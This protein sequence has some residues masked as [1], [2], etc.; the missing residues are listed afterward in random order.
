MPVVSTIPDV[1][2][3]PPPISQTVELADSYNINLPGEIKLTRSNILL[4][5]FL[6]YQGFTSDLLD[7]YNNWIQHTLPQ[8][9]AARVIDNGNGTI[10]RVTRLII[11]KPTTTNSNNQTINLTPIMCRN[12]GTTYASQ[13]YADIEVVKDDEVIGREQMVC[14]GK[15]PVMLGSI[16]CH[17]H[18]KSNQERIEMGECPNDPLS[19][20]IIKGNE[21]VVLMQEKL[22][23]NRFLIFVD[24]ASGEM[25][26][27]MTCNTLKGSMIVT[28]YKTPI[29]EIKLGLAFLGKDE[30]DNPRTLPALSPYFILSDAY[31]NQGIP[32]T[33]DEIQEQILSFVDP[34]YRTKVAMTLLPS[35]VDVTTKADIV[36]EIISTKVI[37]EA[38]RHRYPGTEIQKN[39]LKITPQEQVNMF[40]ELLIE[41]LFPNM[42][43]APIAHKLRQLS[44]MIAVY[45][46][47]ILGYRKPDD[48]NSWSN[49]RV[50]TAGRSL[51]Q[52]FVGVWAK[53]ISTA[54]ASIVKLRSIDVKSISRSFDPIIMEQNL[55]GSFEPNSW[56]VK[57]SY[58]KE[59]ITDILKR[60]SPLALYSHLTLINTPTSRRV[61]TPSIRMVQ[62][63]Q[64]GFVDPVE[65]SEG[66]NCHRWDTYILMSDGSQRQIGQ[67]KDGDEIMTINPETLQIS[68]SRIHSHFSRTTQSHGKG[69]FRITSISG[70]TIVSTGDHPFLTQEGMITVCNLDI[71]RHLL[72]IRPTPVMLP[73]DGANEPLFIEHE[74]KLTNLGIKDSLVAKYILE[75]DN[76]G[77]LSLSRSSPLTPIL[78]RL[79]G[80][81]ISDGHITIHK[82]VAT[83]STKFGCID[84]AH[85]FIADL[86]TLGLT[87]T[88]PKY[89]IT[90]AI[91]YDGREVSH[92]CWDVECYGNIP[93]LFLLLGAPYGK[94]GSKDYSIPDWIETP[95]AIREFLAAFQGGDGSKFFL[96]SDNNIKFP[97]TVQHKDTEHLASGILFMERLEQLFNSLGIKTLGV[98]ITKVA[99]DTHRLSLGFSSDMDNKVR[100]MDVIGYRYCNTKNN[101]GILVSEF[102]KYRERKIAEKIRLKER[103]RELYPE[104]GSYV[105]VAKEL[106]VSAGFVS[107]C[108]RGLYKKTIQPRDTMRIDDWSK[109]VQVKNGTIFVPIE[110]ITPEE[111]CLV[112]DFT[113]DNDNHTMISAG[114]CTSNCG[115]IKAKAV[116]AKVTID[117][118]DALVLEYIK[119]KISDTPTVQLATILIVNGRMTGWCDGEELRQYLVGLRRGGW[120]YPDTSVA[121]VDRILYIYTDAARLVRPLLIV[122]PNGKLVIEEKNLWNAPWPQ[123]VKEQA[124]EYIDPLEQE[125][126]MLAQSIDSLMERRREIDEARHRLTEATNNLNQLRQQGTRSTLLPRRIARTLEG[127]LVFEDAAD[128][129]E[130]MSLDTDTLNDEQLATLYEMTQRK[131]EDIVRLAQATLDRLVQRRPFTHCELDPNAIFGIAAS[132]IPLP[133]HNQAPRNVYQTAMGKQAL[134]IYHSNYQLRFDTTAKTLAFPTR[135]LFETQMNNLLGLNTQP[136]GQMVTVAIMTLGGYNQEDALI[137]NKASI[138][139]GL[140]K[141]AVHRSY[142]ASLES[143]H[144]KIES[145]TRPPIRPGD[146]DNK[147][148][149]LDD[150][151]IAK[152]GSRIEP[153]M[154]IIGKM[155]K[156]NKT[157]KITYPSVYAGIGESG[158][159]VSVL[160][161]VNAKG[162]TMVRVKL[163]DIRDPTYGDKFASRHA[164]KSTVGLILPEHDMPFTRNG[165]RPDI[166]INPHC[167]TGD[168]PVTLASGISRRIDQMAYDGGD[169]VW[170]WDNGLK[171]DKQLERASKGVRKVIRLTLQDGRTIKCTEEHRFLVLMNDGAKYVE[172]KDLR[173]NEHRLVC[174]LEGAVDVVGDDE[175]GWSLTVG[176]HR[177]SMETWHNRD[178]TLALARMLGY[179]LTNRAITS[180]H[181]L[182]G[183]RMSHPIDVQL[184]LD[185]IQLVTGIRPV[186]TYTGTSYV[187]K[188]PAK[189]VRAIASLEGI[190]PT[191]KLSIPK[192]IIQHN[193]PLAVVREFVAGLFGG[194][195]RAPYLRHTNLQGPVLCRVVGRNSIPSLKANMQQLQCVLT[196]LGVASRLV[197]P[198]KLSKQPHYGC[199]FDIRLHIPATTAFSDKVGYRYC[200]YKMARLAAANSYWRY[201]EA[202]KQETIQVTG[203]HNSLDMIGKGIHNVIDKAHSYL[204]NIGALD[205]FVKGYITRHHNSLP[206]FYLQVIDRRE[207]G[208]EEV[209]DISVVNNQSYLANGVTTHNCIPSRMT[210]GKLIEIVASKVASLSGERVNASAFS[211]FDIE[212]FKR[213]LHQYGYERHGNEVM[214]SGETGRPLQAQIFIGP[215]YYQALRH[216]VK[217]KIQMR[218]R[219]EV[220]LITHQPIGG[221]SR[222]GGLR[223][224]EM[225]RD[226]LISH[227]A[228]EVLKER[229]C[230]SS[231]AYKA[232]FCKTCGNLAISNALSQTQTCRCCGNSAKFGTCTVP[233]AYRLL[234]NLLAGASLSLRFKLN[235]V[236]QGKK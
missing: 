11:H 76:L 122:N 43:N 159:V 22:R 104:R 95:L 206:T 205:W 92:H 118:D 134:G 173:L 112:C 156:N 7:S 5:S 210:I 36:S 183:V 123:L 88:K 171:L 196:R 25:V 220:K 146:P 176:E 152:I 143:D 16:L 31:P 23:L 193:C 187:I 50:E 13:V 110:S 67:L 52:L 77:L 215:C 71:N 113:T 1:V 87:P 182:I 21:K 160:W 72:A 203:N 42:V 199:K 129:S 148:A 57:S 55:I 65:T 105:A 165:M 18:G 150:K 15:V 94:K 53:V 6:T 39:N 231:D 54:E 184:F 79:F 74:Q 70:R 35:F 166:V 34:R 214:Y 37:D 190:S 225:E 211:N 212:E 167:F 201:V 232:V 26:C 216:H 41:Q 116:T 128:P 101:R 75:L 111:D 69:V 174:G 14:I 217:D 229:L 114:F 9:V 49:K 207:Y 132:T 97:P 27:R 51:E 120:I 172:A 107:S 153:G 139:R 33:A 126:I 62:M 130:V 40:L 208:Q 219:G 204:D 131:L 169:K 218:A 164:Q 230:T 235:E 161:A 236:E 73:N 222:Q 121:L 170:S 189:W 185:D 108:V 127:E 149:H 78:A 147:Y 99:A 209:Y 228:S 103:C 109:V 125:G 96:T 60:E 195:G 8:Q 191:N 64:L 200:V 178:T 82:G 106:G 163:T 90:E 141:M 83:M 202:V 119:D 162:H 213:N 177:F 233:Y 84:D 81:L 48:R 30:K 85:E 17:L 59:N 93:A 3:S 80:Y 89:K 144:T 44:L 47:Y 124:V 29:N 168:T 138:D 180:A 24:K 98:K 142:K 137:F 188:L 145:F 56:G 135:P 12:N 102:I 192:F 19:Y 20:F 226:A 186:S 28:L 63:S 155:R 46:E 158:E 221:R 115:L 38:I 4:R 197:G 66:A 117:R 45:L 154:V 100:Y 198:R 68:P 227:G 86:R 179:I 140:F 58:V 151:G 136:I 32:A 2:I 224:G 181:K 10:T 157:G 133:D 194:D 223:F 234:Q 91:Y 61:K 175:K